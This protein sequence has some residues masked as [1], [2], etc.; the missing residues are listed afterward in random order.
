MHNLQWIHAREREKS[1]GR[2]E[3]GR[4]RAYNVPTTKYQTTNIII[5]CYVAKTQQDYAYEIF[6]I[7]ILTYNYALK[8]LYNGFPVLIP[9]FPLQVSHIIFNLTPNLSLDFCSLGKPLLSTHN[10]P[11][12]CVTNWFFLNTVYY[13]LFVCI[14]SSEHKLLR[15]RD[16]DTY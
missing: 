10:H 9:A 8:V 4:K 12:L 1:K 6:H 15:G 3:E 13:N 14:P 11:F 7:K 2:R 16:T 5:V